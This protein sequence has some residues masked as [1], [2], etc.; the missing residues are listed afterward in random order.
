MK[1]LIILGLPY[2]KIYLSSVIPNMLGIAIFVFKSPFN[3]LIRYTLP[4]T[5]FILYQY[6]IIAR[7]YSFLLLSISIIALIYP[8]RFDK[9]I[10]YILSLIFLGSIN[11]HALILS[12]G[13]FMLYLYE[14]YKESKINWHPIVLY[15]SFAAFCGY[16]L[17][18]DIDN[19]YVSNW[20]ELNE[21]F[22]QNIATNIFC[23]TGYGF[24]NFYISVST[25]KLIVIGFG[26][27][28]FIWLNIILFTEY[29]KYF[30][31][32]MLPNLLFIYVM[33]FHLWHAGIL[34]LITLLIFWINN[35]SIKYNFNKVMATIFIIAQIIA[36]SYSIYKDITGSY[37]GAK[38]LYHYLLSKNINIDNSNLYSYNTISVCPY[39]EDKRCTY[40]NWK[41]EG[42][43]KSLITAPDTIIINEE[44]V[45]K[46]I[47]KYSKSIQNNYKLE[48][49]KANTIF[50]LENISEM[51]TFYLYYKDI[52][53]K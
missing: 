11:I 43:D 35:N 5:Y 40:W 1:L 42:F 37:S 46:F 39:F 47:E 30:I 10:L 27:A 53:S 33:P 32:L 38:I 16:L 22:I 29:K 48:I 7:N 36:S 13:L 4:L 15:I 44:G 51:E 21:V 26:M 23:F 45:D 50:G 31:F 34:V 25:I 6:N 52:S 12:G 8:Y 17:K 3:R 18:P 49:F 19:Q 2:S 20:L 14:Q 41:K 9:K 24:I 28:Y